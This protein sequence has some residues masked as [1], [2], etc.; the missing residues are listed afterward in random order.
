MAQTSEDAANPDYDDHAILFLE[1]MWGKGHLSPGGTDEIDRIVANVDFEG[2]RVLDIGCGS[3]GNT[4]HLART[5]P[6]AQITGFDVDASCG[7]G[8]AASCVP[9]GSGARGALLV[10]RLAEHRQ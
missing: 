1:M 8:D 9:G 4:L 3:G 6:L 2:K 7:V 10:C 5:T